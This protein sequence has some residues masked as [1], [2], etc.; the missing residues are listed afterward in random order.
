MP[1]L[2]ADSSYVIDLHKVGLLL[3]FAAPDARSN[4]ARISDEDRGLSLRVQ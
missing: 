3:P 2:I 4:L 1:T